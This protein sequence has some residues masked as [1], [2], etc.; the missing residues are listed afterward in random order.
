MTGLHAK[1]C[2]LGS[3]LRSL[4]LKRALL[5]RLLPVQPAN[6]LKE[7]RLLCGL[8]LPGLLKLG[9][10]HG[11]VGVKARLLEALLR[12]LQLKLCLLAREL[13]L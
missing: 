3:D 6:A 10:L 11:R 9:H 5:P 4:L 8:L 12:R 7:L 1:S 2:L 13:P